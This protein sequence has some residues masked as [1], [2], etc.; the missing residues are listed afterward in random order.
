M[1]ARRENLKVGIYQISDPNGKYIAVNTAYEEILDYNGIAFLRL[2]C[3]RPGF[4]DA[5]R[6]LDL[7]I[8]RWSQ[9]D[10]DRQLALDLLPVI[11]GKLKIPCFPDLNTCWHY[12]DKVRQ[13]LLLKPFGFPMVESQIFREKGAALSWA[14]RAD[15]PV[16]FKLRGGA[17]S[18]NVILV[19]DRRQARKLI[20]R[21]F[22][23]GNPAGTIHT[24]RKHP[25]PPLQSLPR[26]SPSGRQS[27]PARQEAGHFSLL[28]V[29]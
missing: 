11:E 9:W 10:S 1:S 17:G 5:V 20:K 14:D 19:E 4:W 23:R 25:L 29:A 21:M 8:L 13:Y 26:V 6:D 28:D 22:G 2:E 3:S 27:L 16:V 7:F 24:P 15:F 12:D 18:Q